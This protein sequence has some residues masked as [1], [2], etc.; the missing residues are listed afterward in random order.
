MYK[1]AATILLKLLITS[2][3]KTKKQQKVP[4]ACQISWRVCQ[5]DTKAE[6]PSTWGFFCSLP[7]LGFSEFYRMAK[8]PGQLSVQLKISIK[9]PTPVPQ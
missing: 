1:Q 7:M 2:S 4:D 6:Q 9:L 3:F 5:F 8:L